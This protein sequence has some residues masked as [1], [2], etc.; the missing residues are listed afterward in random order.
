M[1]EVN[2]DRLLQGC[3]PLSEVAQAYY[4][5]VHNSSAIR[6]FRRHVKEIPQLY[7]ML[8]E[9]GYTDRLIFLTPLQITA[10]I[11]YLG[12]PNQARKEMKL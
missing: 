6:S 4:P 1:K 8:L 12:L 10:L 5:C 7:A 9:V 3:H 2:F 11:R